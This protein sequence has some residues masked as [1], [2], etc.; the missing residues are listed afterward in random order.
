MAA[1]ES[2][3]VHKTFYEVFA[4]D[5]FTIN[6]LA[7]VRATDQG[8][9]VEVY[10]FF[11]DPRDLKFNATAYDWILL[12]TSIVKVVELVVLLMFGASLVAWSSFV[13]W[14]FFF[15]CALLIQYCDLSR[16]YGASLNDWEYDILFGE[17]PTIVKGGGGR[18]LLL[19][20][21]RNF[22]QHPLWNLIWAVGAVV[23]TASL[24]T[25]YAL[26]GR[27][28]ARVVYI[29]LSFQV[30]WML[31]RTFY[32]Q[33]AQSPDTV[34][35]PF[36]REG[37]IQ[38]IPA[39]S[40]LRRRALDLL[41]A[42][43][44]YR[45]SLHPRGVR[46]HSEEPLSLPQLQ[47]L[48][49]KSGFVIL[50]TLPQSPE[51]NDRSSVELDVIGIVGDCLLGSAAWFDRFKLTG[52]ERDDEKKGLHLYDSCL[53][54][55]RYGGR[56]MTLNATRAL[57]AP[58]ERPR[59]DAIAEHGTERLQAFVPRGAPAGGESSVPKLWYCWI[60]RED[61]KWLQ[62][63][64]QGTHILGKRRAIVL[65]SSQITQLLEGRTLNIGNWSVADMEKSVK[66][67]K[68]SGDALLKLL[69]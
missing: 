36:Q 27:Q 60:P 41:L 64:S 57:C 35:F 66:A 39:N 45:I 32:Y 49:E 8:E 7:L 67:A 17:L 65:S 53:I 44:R 3:S 56:I 38:E 11:N 1:T 37:L 52:V 33:V 50:L 12:L 2:Q 21:P 68:Q 23:S 43:S 16:G 62:I 34:F 28:N 18:K 54:S 14:L 19:G 10:S 6:Q 46:W 13:P 4:L 29:W 69:Q 5:Q 20:A 55:L 47:E 51:D 31:L 40:A 63:C 22:R 59:N 15:L 9:P 61:G 24:V 58:S 25:T 48:F 42:L 30:G 26:L